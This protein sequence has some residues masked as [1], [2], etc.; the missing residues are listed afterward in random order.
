MPAAAGYLELDGACRAI[1]DPS[2]RRE[3]T[4][5]DTYWD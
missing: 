1:G 4:V 3:H 2:S 5:K